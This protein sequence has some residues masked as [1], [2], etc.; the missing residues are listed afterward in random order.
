MSLLVAALLTLTLGTFVWWVHFQRRQRMIDALDAVWLE[1]LTALAQAFDLTLDAPERVLRGNIDDHPLQFGIR[2]AWGDEH[3][4]GFVVTG[5]PGALTV[6]PRQSTEPIAE[7]A[8][9]AQRY[10]VDGDAPAWLDDAMQQT[11]LDTP[12]RL[13]LQGGV[14][15]LRLLDELDDE[16][17]QIGL[18]AVRYV[19]RG[20][21]PAAAGEA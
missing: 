17:F 5:V 20:G 19:V 8:T 4:A 11:L 6:A 18:D 1:R 2:P 10:V 7:D 12:M 15:E 14:L 3:D 16:T 13:K 9:F 21:K